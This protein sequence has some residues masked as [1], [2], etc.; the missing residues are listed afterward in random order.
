MDRHGQWLQREPELSLEACRQGNQEGIFDVSRAYFYAPVT[1]P[2][3]INIPVEDWEERDEGLVGQLQISLS[4]KRDAAQNW[5]ATYIKILVKIGFQR[6]RASSCNFVRKKKKEE[7][8][9]D[10][11]R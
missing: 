6:S 7:H 10:S 11:A 8:Q 5:A 9:D 1:R 3:F 2:L 4:G